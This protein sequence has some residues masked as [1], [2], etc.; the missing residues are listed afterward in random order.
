MKLDFSNSMVKWFIG[1][2]EYQSSCVTFEAFPFLNM[3]RIF[4][5]HPPFR[6]VTM[7]IQN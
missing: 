3:A 7:V 4:S 5:I 2:Q 1:L 6:E